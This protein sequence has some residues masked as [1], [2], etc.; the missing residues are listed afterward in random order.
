MI[1]ATPVNAIEP[2]PPPVAEGLLTGVRVETPNICI[3][4]A[5]QSKADLAA[6]LNTTVEQI[7]WVN[8]GLPDEVPPGALVIIPPGYRVFQETSLSA[9]ARATGLSEEMLSAANPNVA[10]N[11]ALPA[12]AVLSVPALYSVGEE[13]PLGAVAETLNLSSEA[14][15][16]ANPNVG[17]TLPAG[18]VLIVPPQEEK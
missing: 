18:V 17:E 1:I 7:E 3:V 6:N 12:G 11:A 14:L 9:V 4:P 5:R 8:P 2:P 16:S 13:T 10:A 15:L